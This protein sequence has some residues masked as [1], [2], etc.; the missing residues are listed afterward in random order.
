MV[1]VYKKLAQFA[2]RGALP[3][4]RSESPV[5]ATDNKP[6]CVLHLLGWIIGSRGFSSLEGRP[7]FW[8]LQCDYHAQQD[9]E[10]VQ[11]FTNILHFPYPRRKLSSYL[12]S[13]LICFAYSWPSH[14]W[15]HT[16]YRILF[17]TSKSSQNMSFLYFLGLFRDGLHRGCSGH[18]P[19]LPRKICNGQRWEVGHSDSNKYKKLQ[20][21]VK[22]SLLHSVIPE[23]FRWESPLCQP[24][25]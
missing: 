8:V 6:S 24:L 22:N 23:A 15:N 19:V 4:R 21:Q 14:T 16:M 13:P 12:L 11:N 2:V 10:D 7:E 3:P 9:T 20:L 5:C 18:G 25:A 1:F 17:K